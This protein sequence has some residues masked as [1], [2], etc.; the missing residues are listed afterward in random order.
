MDW[1]RLI[2]ASIGLACASQPEGARAQERAGPELSGSIE[3]A[4]DYRFRGASR[5]AGKPVVQAV[6]DAA[7]PIDSDTSV[8]SGAVGAVTGSNSDYGAFQSQVYV[9]VEQ[10][11]GAFRLAFGGR[12]YFFPDVSAKDYYEIFGSGRTQLGPLSAKLGFA[13]APNQRSYGGKR[14]IYVYSDLDAGIPST[15]FTV[16]THI[17][18]ED[19]ARFRDKVDWGL[20]LTY[21]RSP[22]SLGLGYVDS[23]RS[24]LFLKDGKLKNGSDGALVVTLGASF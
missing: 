13:L 17:G 3:A 22:W 5:S 11:I 1:M 10:E 6:L 8:F 9:G 20:S 16:A 24:A 7:I 19:N 4:T 18:W 15:P 21:V 23:N 12:G 2:W 14:G